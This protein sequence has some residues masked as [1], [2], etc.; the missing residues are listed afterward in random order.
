MSERELVIY[1]HTHIYW[2]CASFCEILRLP[3]YDKCQNLFSLWDLENYSVEH[4]Q[5]LSNFSERGW[6]INILRNSRY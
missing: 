5:C 2:L 6:G 1:V 3:L 4:K